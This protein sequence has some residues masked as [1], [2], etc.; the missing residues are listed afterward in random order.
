MSGCP[1]WLSGKES[2]CTEGDTGLIPGW[3]RCP[4]NPLQY[5]CLGNPVDR[6]AWQAIVHGVAKSRTWLS[7]ETTRKMKERSS[8]RN[9]WEKWEHEEWMEGGASWRVG[10]LWGGAY[11]SEPLLLPLRNRSAVFCLCFKQVYLFICFWL[12]GVFVWLRGFLWL[13]WAG[14]VEHGLQ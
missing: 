10:W 7:D 9:R 5:S 11:Y 6:G 4:G 14:V 13:W 8:K 3:G 1:W 12:C 2:T